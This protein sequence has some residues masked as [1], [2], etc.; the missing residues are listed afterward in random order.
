M[1]RRIVMILVPVLALVVLAL[2]AGA[3]R[4]GVR[5]ESASAQTSTARAAKAATAAPLVK[6][7]AVSENWAGY[8]ADGANFSG[9]SGQWVQPSAKPSS[10]STYSAFW[11]GIGGASQRSSALEQVGTQADYVH[12]HAIYYAWYELVPRAPV[13]LPVSVSPGDHI[14]ARVTVN[15]TRV[16]VSL[17]NLTTGQAAKRTLIMWSPS[18]SSAEWIAE[19]PS[20]CQGGTTGNCQPLALADFGKVSFT[21]ASA[22]ADGHTGPID[23]SHWSAE[24]VALS[25]ASDAAGLLPGGFGFGFGGSGFGFGF[26]HGALGFGFGPTGAGAGAA[27]ASSTAGAQPSK[28]TAAGSAF[29]VA[30]EPDGPQLSGLFGDGSGGA[31]AGSSAGSGTSGY[32][33]GVGSL[34]PGVGGL[35][36]GGYLPGAGGFGFGSGGFGFG[37]GGPGAGGYGATLPGVTVYVS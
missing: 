8:V 2:A 31:G 1:R 15:G 12:G 18:T 25:P 6:Q 9:V 5:S 11:V 36:P 29:A 26:G 21:H 30:Y 32:L 35:L 16:S 13:K 20:T 28:L 33:P 17:T 24:P 34:L 10:R 23:D 14:S 19:A 22:T 4:I 37:S 7:A 3:A 27:A